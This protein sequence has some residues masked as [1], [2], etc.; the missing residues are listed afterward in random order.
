MFN[1]CLT[2]FAVFNF[3]CKFWYLHILMCLY[4][5]NT[6]F[7]MHLVS[8]RPKLWKKEKK[9]DECWKQKQWSWP[10][11]CDRGKGD[12]R[13]KSEV[14]FPC[15]VSIVFYYWFLR[16]LSTRGRAKYELYDNHINKSAIKKRKEREH[17]RKK[18]TSN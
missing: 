6:A 7:L 2:E 11:N 12:N 5:R 3:L 10:E 8:V 16:R 14:Q 9:N 15:N 4:S 17:Y 18:M 1:I 13:L